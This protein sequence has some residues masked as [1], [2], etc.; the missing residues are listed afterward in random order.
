MAFLKLS[1]DVEQMFVGKRLYGI[2]KERLAFLI[3]SQFEAVNNYELVLIAR[4]MDLYNY[5]FE[6]KYGITL[7]ME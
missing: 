6:V 1:I 7:N 5:Q 2:D 4:A 3:Q